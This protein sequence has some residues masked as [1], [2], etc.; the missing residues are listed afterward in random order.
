MIMST[1]DVLAVS[2][3]KLCGNDFLTQIELVARAKPCGIILRE[4]DLSEAEYKQLAKKVVEICGIDGVNCILHTFTDAAIS[5][6]CT[7]IHLP[8]PFLLK[9]AG[10][11]DFFETIGVSTHSVEEAVEAQ[12][13]G[14]TY[15]T[16]GH[17][18]ATDCKKGIAPRGLPFLKSVVESIEI[19]VYAIGGITPENAKAAAKARAH[20]VC[21]MSGLMQCD[22]P[23]EYLSGF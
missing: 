22:N 3:R 7:A 4:K 18:F 16:T 13:L 6:G 23:T 19:P 15:V 11:L 9:E 14:A 12:R 21:V 2:N 10:K 1:F 17:I 8:L 20:G 5:L